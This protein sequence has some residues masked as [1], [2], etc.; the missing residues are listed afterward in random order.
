MH[1]LMKAMT[2]NGLPHKEMRMNPK[3]N[4]FF[5]IFKLIF[6]YSKGYNSSTNVW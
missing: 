5:Q 6:D 4:K 1:C 3:V 2:E